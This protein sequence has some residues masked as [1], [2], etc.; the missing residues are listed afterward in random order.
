MCCELAECKKFFEKLHDAVMFT[1]KQKEKFRLIH[2]LIDVHEM[3]MQHS[4]VDCVQESGEHVSR[5]DTV[6][7]TAVH[8]GDDL[9]DTADIIGFFS[10]VSRELSEGSNKYHRSMVC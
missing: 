10:A 7:Y 4:D 9:D 3:H 1:Q 6:I 8:R 2:K 5:S